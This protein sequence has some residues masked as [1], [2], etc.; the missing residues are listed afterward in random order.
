MQLQQDKEL[1]STKPFVVN[2][3]NS[4]VNQIKIKKQERFP[5]ISNL[6]SINMKALQ[7]DFC[8]T[9]AHDKQKLKENK[10]PQNIPPENKRRKLSFIIEDIKE[11]IGLDVILENDKAAQINCNVTQKYRKSC[12]STPN[13]SKFIE[14]A[15]KD[16]KKEKRKLSFGGKQFEEEEIQNEAFQELPVECESP[17]LKKNKNDFMFSEITESVSLTKYKLNCLKKM[18]APE[19]IDQ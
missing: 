7:D 4:E 14:N 18:K 9:K 12:S 2:E 1:K 10:K 6:N 8:R 13:F 3:A 5:N 11:M 17:E 15:A 19:I 16:I